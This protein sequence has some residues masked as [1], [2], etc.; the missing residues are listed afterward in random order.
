MFLP[1]EIEAFWLSLQISLSATLLILGPTSLLAYMM[2]YYSFWGKGLLHMI[3]KLPLVLPPVVVGYLLL[4]LLGK[5]G[6]I[7][8]YLYQYFGIH[9]AL[10]K[11]GAIIACAVIAFPLLLQMAHSAFK[12]NNPKIR[13]AALSL[14]ASPLRVWFTISLPQA[15]PGLLAGFVL[16][17]G[18]SLGEFGATITFVSNIAGHTRTL[19]LAIHTQ[20]QNP[21]PQAEASAYRLVI[22]SIL[23]SVL[24]L[25]ISEWLQRKLPSNS[26]AQ[27]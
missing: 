19:P 24:C 4:L 23:L 27:N 17:W 14:G 8:S 15:L 11:G 13:E 6:L 16:A 10:Q 2:A 5:Q 22:L 18:R 7:G 12:A 3:C 20:I 21:S 25:G 9:L 26:S 1:A